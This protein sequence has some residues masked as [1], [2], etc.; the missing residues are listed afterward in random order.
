MKNLELLSDVE[1]VAYFKEMQLMEES[2]YAMDMSGD[3]GDI[4]AENF[5]AIWI[6]FEDEFVKRGIQVDDCSNCDMP[7]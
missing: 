1:L 6:L 4:I 2:E 3:C 7:Y 5:E